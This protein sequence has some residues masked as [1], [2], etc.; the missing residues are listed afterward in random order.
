MEREGRMHSLLEI[1]SLILPV[2][3]GRTKKERDKAQDIAFHITIGFTKALKDEETDKMEN[4][5]CYSKVCEQIK[6]LTLKNKFSLI[7][8]LAFE[9]L[10]TVKKLLSSQKKTRVRVCVHKIH[11]PV[12]NLEGGV[13]YT[14]GDFF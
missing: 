11:P 1:K 10:I 3:I 7:E 8:K 6:Q 14:C 4:S 9:T 5:V 12:A 13:S 2:Y